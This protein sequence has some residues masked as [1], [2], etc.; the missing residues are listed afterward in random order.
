MQSITRERFFLSKTRGNAFLR[1]DLKKGRVM[2]NKL[3]SMSKLAGPLVAAVALFVAAACGDSTAPGSGKLTLQLTDA[4]FSF[5]S[6]AR[7]DLWVVRID[8]KTS[9]TDSADTEAGKND[10][11]NGGNTDPARGWVTV[12]TPNQAYNLLDLQNGTVTNLG[13]PTL[14]TGTYKGFRLILDTDKSSITLKNGKVLN[15]TSNPGIKF[16]SAARTG[17]KIV[18]DK[19]ISLTTNGT[20]M[21]IDFNL[22]KSF[23]MRGNSISQNGLL[24]K[25]VIRATARD[26]TGAISGTVRATT[27]TGTPVADATVDV[28]VNGTAVG[29]TVSA[30]LIESTKTDASGNFTAAFLAAGTYAVRARPPAAATTLHAAILQ[31]IAVTSGTTTSGTTIILP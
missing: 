14:A 10:D 21:V 9:D 3:G 17:V 15:G 24:F 2:S 19:P 20:V 28:L 4:P 16:P 29:D 27:A 1:T 31:G 22:G 6:V 7:T 8:A 23:V 5:D 25:P 18:L 13:Q 11:T 30:N 26:I 12:A